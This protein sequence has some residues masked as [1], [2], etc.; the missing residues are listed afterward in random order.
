MPR[1]RFTIDAGAVRRNAARLVDVLGGSELWAVVKADGYGHGALDVSRAALAGGA[2]ALC[3]ATVAEGATLRA[4][5]PE[6]RIVVLGPTA[7]DELAAAREARLELVVGAPGS[8]PESLP[9]HL[10]LD[11]G[12]GRWGLV[13]AGGRR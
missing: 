6:P 9:L 2:R 3:V 7:D 10:K 1:S 13:R 5:L 12:M 11:T 4:A 8:R